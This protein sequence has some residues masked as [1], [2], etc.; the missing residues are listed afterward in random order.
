MKRWAIGALIV[1]VLA[2]SLL[3]VRQRL[4]PSYST[5]NLLARTPNSA[6][7]YNLCTEAFAYAHAGSNN[8]YKT[9][10][11]FHDPFRNA[12]DT[13]IPLLLDMNQRDQTISFGSG[14]KEDAVVESPHDKKGE[15]TGSPW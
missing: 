7:K 5:L 2:T 12:N 4:T 13:I 11:T 3:I 10:Y 6:Y 14:Q 15:R 1:I 8:P 9:D